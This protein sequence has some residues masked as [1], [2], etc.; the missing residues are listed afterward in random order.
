MQQLLSTVPAAKLKEQKAGMKERI[1]WVKSKLGWINHAY[2]NPRPQYKKIIVSVN[3]CNVQGNNEQ[4]FEIFS[5]FRVKQIVELISRK[6]NIQL[7]DYA[8]TANIN[9]KN[10]V[11]FDD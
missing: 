11:L 4:S 7:E 5:S 1:A 3:L 6:L 2:T 9:G 8:L 10:Y